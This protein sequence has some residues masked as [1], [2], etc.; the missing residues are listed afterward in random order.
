MKNNENT[1]Q[2]VFENQKNTKIEYVKGTGIGIQ[3]IKNMMEQM[4]GE[5]E[6]INNENRYAIV[7]SF[8]IYI[9]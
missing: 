9:E 7:L 8:P 5:S 6:I 1:I 2:I 4:K 3:N